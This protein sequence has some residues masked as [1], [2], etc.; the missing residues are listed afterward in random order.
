MVAKPAFWNPVFHCGVKAASPADSPA[1]MAATVWSQAFLTSGLVSAMTLP[2]A[3][4]IPCGACATIALKTL[5]AA[6]NQCT[7]LSPILVWNVLPRLTK[8]SQVFI[9]ALSAAGSVGRP[10][11]FISDGR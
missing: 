7:F 10:A 8:S 4:Y 9:W 1:W 2:L 3:S 6:S 11:F 5:L